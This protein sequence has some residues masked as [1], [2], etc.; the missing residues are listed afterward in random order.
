[1]KRVSIIIF[2]FGFL[3][4]SQFASGQCGD[5]LLDICHGKLGDTRFLKSFPVELEEKKSDGSLPITRYNMV[6]N[7]GNTYKIFACNASEFT[8]KVIISLYH[9][10]RLMGTTYLVEQK[11][12]LPHIQFNCGMSGVYHIDFYFEDGKKGCA[13]GVVSSMK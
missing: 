5:A 12:H 8:G 7:S 2:F 9:Q 6:F 4:I 13:V 3:S 1:M 11:R 10:D